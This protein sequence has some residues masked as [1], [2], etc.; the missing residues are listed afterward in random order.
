MPDFWPLQAYRLGQDRR[1]L[2]EKK[3]RC[4]KHSKREGKFSDEIC[5]RAMSFCNRLLSRL[6]I[7]IFSNIAIANSEEAKR[8]K[9]TL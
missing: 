8:E 3:K 6:S 5:S 1:H 9:K 7:S 4:Q 2:L